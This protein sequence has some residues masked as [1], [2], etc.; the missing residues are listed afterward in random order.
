MPG[1]F[2]PWITVAI[3]AATYLGLALGRIPKLR[4]DRA[5]IAFA[6][7]GLMLCTSVLT[8]T[9]AVSPDSID[10]ETLFLLF[11]MMVVVGF[12]R[13]SGF[14]ARVTH[15]MLDR[16]RTPRGLLAA[17]IL[18]GGLL[19]AFLVND[20]VCLA[21]TPL[22]IHIARRLNFNPLPHL[23][24]LATASNIGSVGT[25]TGNPQNMII[26]VQSKI[27]YGSFAV[28]LMPVALLG[29]VIDFLVIAMIYRSTLARSSIETD[30]VIVGE[31]NHGPAR[32]AM[33]T[34]SS[35]YSGR[36]WP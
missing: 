21:L 12:L 35:G 23:I 2:R 24:G 29:L 18:L 9:Q 31:R 4:T 17:I 32:D 16:I 19:S 34:C 10:Y 8:L 36:P 26:G 14:F 33:L 1:S 25:I 28:H 3:F 13:F 30:A 20:I 6:G 7:A 22:V 15:G 27:S 5:G 11:G